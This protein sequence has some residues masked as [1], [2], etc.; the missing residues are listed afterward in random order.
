MKDRLTNFFGNTCGRCYC[1][2][3]GLIIRSCQ[4]YGGFE[5]IF[6]SNLKTVHMEIFL[7]LQTKIYLGT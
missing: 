3:W 7:L 6:F 2:A 4:G 1:F 5:N